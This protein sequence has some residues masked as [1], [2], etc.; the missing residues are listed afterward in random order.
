M[1]KFEISYMDDYPN[2]F[3]FLDITFCVDNEIDIY[4]RNTYGLLDC[5]GDVGGLT[6]FLYILIGLGALKCSK[7]KMKAELTSSL[8]F[9]NSQALK[10]VAEKILATTTNKVTRKENGDFFIK[11]PEFLDWEYMG[12]MFRC[13]C[14]RD[15]V[16]EEYLDLV[17][18]GSNDYNKDIDVV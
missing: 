7:L 3:A 18:K 8:N 6:E 10:K 4:E 17:E 16:F 1:S 9:I 11:V 12:S 14:C 15:K 2:F 5:I 13:C